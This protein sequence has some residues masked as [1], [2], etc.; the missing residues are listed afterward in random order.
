MRV[1]AANRGSRRCRRRGCRRDRSISAD[2]SRGRKSR[3]RRRPRRSQLPAA[4]ALVSLACDQEQPLERKQRDPARKR[5]VG[6]IYAP[7]IF[8]LEGVS[9]GPRERIEQRLEPGSLDP[10]LDGVFT[11]EYLKVLGFPDVE[12]LRKRFEQFVIV[13]RRMHGRRAQQ[14]LEDGPPWRTP[15]GFRDQGVGWGCKVV[16][17]L[18]GEYAA[19]AQLREQPRKQ[20]IVVPH[21]VQRGIGKNQIGGRWR[22]PI[23][24]VGLYPLAAFDLA[25]GL[26]KH[27]SGTVNAGDFRRRPARSQQL[28]RVARAA[29]EIEDPLGMLYCDLSEQV[30][31]GSQ[32]SVRELQILIRVPSGGHLLSRSAASADA[33][34]KPSISRIARYRPIV[35]AGLYNG[36][37]DE[38]SRVTALTEPYHDRQQEATPSDHRTIPHQG[39]RADSDDE[40]RGTCGF[41]C[42]R[43]LQSLCV[44]IG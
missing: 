36:P 3:A 15:D 30:D 18:H 19:R 33:I 32:A 42:C 10:L 1:R 28:G 25:R 37:L 20:S 7:S 22:L 41:D 11:A 24:E 16:W 2:R 29:A 17:H 14:R 44:E 34:D 35:A 26:R 4:I 40:S 13:G 12:R 8:G 38:P 27:R 21:P 43:R 31:C 5:R 39:G 9:I 23:G 6:G